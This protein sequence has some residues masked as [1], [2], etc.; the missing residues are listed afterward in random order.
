M[1]LFSANY[2]HLHGLKTIIFDSLKEAGGQ[3]KLL[4]PFKKIFDIPVFDSITGTQLIDRLKKEAPSHADFV[5]HHRVTNIQKIAD[6]F[7]IDNTY[8]AKSIII[9]TGN[10][11]FTPKKFPLKLNDQTKPLV[12]YYIDQPQNFAN[13]TVG[14]FGGGDSALDFALELAQQ[15]QTIVKLIHR[16]ND[17]RGL[18]SS[19]EQLKSLKNV[20]I[21][22]PYLPKT[23]SIVNNQLDVGLKQVGE[24]HILHHLFDQIVVAYGF[25]A[26]NNL[27]KNWGV[28]VNNS[29]ITVSSEMK[30]NLA[31]IYA[32]GDVA[33]YPGR[34]PI[35]GVGFGEAQIAVNSIMRSLFPEKTLTVHST[36]R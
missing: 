2:A 5:L 7:L 33:T 17:F 27:V 35:I 25:R 21:L 20:E 18:E 14:V 26:N 29:Q 36:S 12:H 1:G 15:K 23:I 19:I 16:R 24:D 28:N 13:Q 34:V 10:G 6:E 32:V 22:T 4:Y 3:P 30:T 11:S 8:L 9:A 31:G